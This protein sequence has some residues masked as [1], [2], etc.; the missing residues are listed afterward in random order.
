MA[1]TLIS[2]RKLQLLLAGENGADAA[3]GRFVLSLNMKLDIFL[4]LEFGLGRR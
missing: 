3:S 2:A 4:S 1:I